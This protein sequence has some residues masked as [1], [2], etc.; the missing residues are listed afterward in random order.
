M[1]AAVAP[2]S[3]LLLG[4]AYEAALGLLPDCV[5]VMLA[6]ERGGTDA[7]LRQRHTKP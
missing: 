3:T 5:G 4:S 2:A 6:A 1:A 7:V